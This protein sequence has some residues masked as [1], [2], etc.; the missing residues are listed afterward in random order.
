MAKLGNIDVELVENLCTEI[1]SKKSKDIRCFCFLAYSKLRND[2]WAELSEV[3]SALNHLCDQDFEQLHPQRPR[4]RSMALK[5]LS[6]PRF[7]DTAESKTPS[8][9]HSEDLDKLSTSLDEL[10]RALEPHFPEG[11]PFPGGFHKLVQRWLKAAQAEQKQQ[12]K[13]PSDDTASD[14]SESATPSATATPRPALQAKAPSSG[15]TGP[16]TFETTKQALLQ[17]QKAA[18]FII[19]KEP[20]KAVGYKLLAQVKWGV[21]DNLPPN[22]GGKTQVPGPNAAQRDYFQQLQS[23]G[24]WSEILAK[25]PDAFTGPGGNLWLDLQRLATVAAEN[26]GPAY[27]D[28]ATAVSTETVLFCQRLK[29][30][31][32]LQFADGTPCCD[33]ATKAWIAQ[34]SEQLFAQGATSTTGSSSATSEQT[35]QQI[36]EAKKLAMSAKYQEAIALLEQ[37]KQQSSSEKDNFYRSLHIGIILLQAKRIVAAIAIF[38]QLNQKVEQLQL[39]SWAPEI[40]VELWGAMVQAY[41]AQKSTV[42]Q[43]EQI[44]QTIDT[45]I[46]N[47]AKISAAAALQLTS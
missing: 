45:I 34:L 12:E 10:K 21:F 28:I 4:A 22:Q 3:F 30:V 35:T 29:G 24:K 47:I 37:A 36:Q 26:I 43:P 1:V 14:K 39:Q 46:G 7:N 17:A 5:W 6:E 16:S 13:S 42:Q 31:E 8:A 41:R 40:A 9:E 2:K 32:N 15:S 18:S 23:Q 11:A 25:Y 27:A 33:E 38:N 44:E 19:S 20:V